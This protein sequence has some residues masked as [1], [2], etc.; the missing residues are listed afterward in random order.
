MKRIGRPGHSSSLASRNPHRFDVE[1]QTGG[2]KT[3]DYMPVVPSDVRTLWNHLLKP[4]RK[5]KQKDNKPSSDNTSQMYTMA[6]L[7]AYCNR[8]LAVVRKHYRDRRLP[9]PMHTIKHDRKT[10]RL[11]TLAECKAIKAFFESQQPGGADTRRK[12]RRAR[13]TA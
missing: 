7:A 2:V 12:R 13:A 5:V 3:Y 8:S 9:D 10:T 11:Y 6:Q 4:K 1:G